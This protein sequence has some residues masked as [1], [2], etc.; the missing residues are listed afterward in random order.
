MWVEFPTTWFPGKMEFFFRR[1]TSERSSLRLDQRWRIRFS[2]RAWWM[3][4]RT[5]K[6]VIIFRRK[7]WRAI[8]GKRMT[9]PSR[10]PRRNTHKP[11]EATAGQGGC[12]SKQPVAEPEGKGFALDSVGVRNVLGDGYIEI[13]R[14]SCRE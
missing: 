8:F 12:S 2:A 5:R 11:A 6:C 14:A 3:R 4:Q 10:F 7:G 9:G 13:G 1:E